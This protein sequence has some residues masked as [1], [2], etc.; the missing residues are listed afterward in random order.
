MAKITFI[1][2]AYLL[3]KKVKTFHIAEEQ[4]LALTR[5]NTV[6]SNLKLKELFK[7]EYLVNL[8]TMIRR[9][10]CL[11]VTSPNFTNKENLKS[12]KLAHFTSSV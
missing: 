1:A 10:L 4:T 7:T 11:L 5:L 12:Y 9:R 8:S 3:V 6:V 2:C